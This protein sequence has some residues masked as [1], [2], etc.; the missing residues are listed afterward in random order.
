VHF[1]G[2]ARMSIGYYAEGTLA[3]KGSSSKPV[4]FG[5]SD[6]Q[7]PGS[8]RGIAVYRNGEV[9]LEHATLQHGGKREAEGVL[10]GDNKSRLSVKQCAF[11]G[12]KAG[13]VLRG[14]EVEAIAI[15]GNA[16][17]NT[18]LAMRLPAHQVGALGPGNGYEGEARV[19]IEG[20]KTGKDAKWVP[21][22]GAKVELAGNLG[23]DGGTLEIAAGYALVVADGVGI[24]VG[25]YENAALKL[26]GTASEPIRIVGA[27]DDAGTWKSVVFHRHAHGNEIQHVQ[28]VNAGG[29]GGVV[30]KR[31]A[32]GIVDTL[33]CEK[34]SGP[35]LQRDD[36]ADVQA[37]NVK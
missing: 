29:E 14:A 12:N 16:F 23:V 19:I 34:C 28:L 10:L 33:S 13:I 15:D 4:V 25:Y 31:E 7:E 11:K 6:R 21:Q 1:D 27:R 18:P 8:W 26:L 24:D 17:E 36:K 37:S 30:F 9:E 32:D 35:A 5:S 2:D 20:G 3:A 22:K